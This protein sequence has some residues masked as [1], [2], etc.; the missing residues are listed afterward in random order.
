MKIWFQSSVGILRHWSYLKTYD[1]YYWSANKAIFEGKF[2]NYRLDMFRG[3][4]SVVSF[5]EDKIISSYPSGKK[6]TFEERKCIE[7]AGTMEA[8]YFGVNFPAGTNNL[9]GILAPGSIASPNN[10]DWFCPYL[11]PFGSIMSIGIELLGKEDGDL[12]IPAGSKVL[13]LGERI[14]G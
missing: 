9:G 7:F 1:K 5:S 4:I 8:L 3:S 14:S 6:H 2:P 10:I 11:F 12:F 13:V